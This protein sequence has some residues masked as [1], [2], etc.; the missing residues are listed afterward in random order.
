M[1]VMN[2]EMNKRQKLALEHTALRMLNLRLKY[3]DVLR[4]GYPFR[5]VVKDT[6]IACGWPIDIGSYAQ[7]AWW[8]HRRISGF[9]A[10]CTCSPV[11]TSWIND[12]A[13]VDVISH[14]NYDRQMCKYHNTEQVTHRILTHNDVV[15]YVCQRCVGGK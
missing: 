6:C 9:Y 11:V 14:G 5:I 2:M 15:Q 10:H 3:G 7:Q 13:Y 1:E 4:V 12:D 8:N